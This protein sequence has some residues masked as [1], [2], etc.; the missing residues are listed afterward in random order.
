MPQNNSTVIIQI[1]EITE[2]DR[3]WVAQKS[4]E[5]WGA[6][7]VVVHCQTY[8]PAR[9]PGY[10]AIVDENKVGLITYYIENQACEIITLQSLLHGQ[11][12]GSALIHHV[13]QTARENACQRVWLVTTN[14]N[15]R[16]FHFYQ[17]M[18]FTLCKVLLGAVDES[19]QVKPEIPLLG[20]HGIPIRDELELEI[21]LGDNL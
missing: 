7:H 10:L 4:R 11:G 5:A 12:V 3:E 6:E 21:W 15:L 16:A 17:Q 9:L 8:H 19:R 13:I 2:E 14:D 18:G 20:Q 1:R